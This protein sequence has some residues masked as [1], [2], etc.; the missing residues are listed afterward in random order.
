MKLNFRPTRV[1]FL[2]FETQSEHDLTKSSS[3]KYSKDP[4]TKALTCVVKVDDKLFKFGPYLDDTD[5]ETLRRI[6][7]SCTLVAHNAP[8]DAA[9]WENVL[10]L[11]ETEWFDTL[12]CA[13]AGGFPGGLDKLSKAIGGRGKHKD[14]ER[15]IKMLCVIKNGKVPAVGA[16]HQLLMDYN[17]QDVE[18]LEIIYDRVKS[19]G[20]P[21]VM[22]V[23]HTINC[24]G[25]P[26]DTEMLAAMTSMY[27]QN[28]KEYGQQFADA[29]E[30]V[31]PKS[32]KQVREWLAERGINIDSVGKVE[33][34]KFLSEPESY[35]S[36]SNPPDLE[37][38][39]AAKEAI[40]LRRELAGVGKGKI[41]AAQR[42][43]DNGFVYDQFVYFGTIPGR[44]S[45]RGLQLHNMPSSLKSVD[46]R[47][48]QLDYDTVKAYAVAASEETGN[49]VTVSDC[50]NV[51]LRRLVKVDN[52]LTADYG[53]IQARALA[54]I[55]ESPSMLAAYKNPK[56][57][58][59][60]K[61]GDKVFGHRINKKTEPLEYVL[62]K[63]L[64][65]G[66]GFGMS[67]AKFRATCML[68][69][70]R[71]FMKML[72]ASGIDLADSV[73]LYRKTYPEVP[74]LWATLQETVLA[75]VAGTP[76]HAGRCD[77]L[78]VGRDLHC[79]F[80]SGRP[81]V[82]R[83]ARTEMEVPGYC[84][85]YNMPEVP[86]P[87][88]KYDGPRGVDFLYGGKITENICMGVERDLVADALVKCEQAGLTPFLHVHDEIACLGDEKHLELLCEIMST[89]PEWA[90]TLPILVEGYSG[91]QWTKNPTGYKQ[92]NMLTGVEI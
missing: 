71:E 47:D 26:I 88:V 46:M 28:T 48:V 40:E 62:C 10:G 42:L 17:V 39:T 59:Y 45:S 86:V 32:P 2:D 34:G 9:I 56:E 29:T 79:V 12:P 76:G 84:K 57:S 63:A 52:I 1:A 65:L 82:Y 75:A 50:L 49:H 6:A 37:M 7:E 22:T 60:L 91:P 13:R 20:E 5:K 51:A 30:G 23:D 38:L 92:C 16:A 54:W 70:S 35:F 66:C 3:R 83:N 58:L 27:E 19:F 36:E 80:P 31:N 89:G 25:L 21:D 74:R 15:L 61:M 78:M 11:P 55:A 18:E 81:T 68:R 24:R 43:V 53:A 73:K 87:T 33:I 90:N 72:D 8:F 41:D 69:E 67:G 77:F 44:W 4:T 14:G 85:L 64:V